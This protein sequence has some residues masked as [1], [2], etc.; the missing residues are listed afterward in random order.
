MKKLIYIT[1]AF[2]CATLTSCNDDDNKL[3]DITPTDRGTVTDNQGNVYNW[4]RI[5]DQM[6]TTTNAKNGLSLADA[7]YYD[8]FGYSYILTSEKSITDYENNYLPKYGNLLSF[9]DAID[10]APEGWRLPSDEDWQKLEKALGMGGTSK[11]GNRGKGIAY[12]LQETESGCELGLSLC[13][14]CVPLKNLGYFTIKLDYVGEHGYYWTSTI[15]PSYQ[16]GEMVYFRRIT[17]N[18]STVARNC[19]SSQAYLAVRWV[20]DVK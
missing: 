3:T 6:W 14:G 11:K 19:I 10:S 18:M 16:D 5:G 2:I 12:S 8:N 4:V 9:E 17:A 13:G 15:D 20:R 7:E 1:I